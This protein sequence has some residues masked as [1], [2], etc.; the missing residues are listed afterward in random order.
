MQISSIPD[1]RW[2]LF[3]KYMAESDKLPPTMGALKQHIM[4]THVQA[5]I[6]GQASLPHQDLL[7][8]LQNGYHKGDDGQLKPTTTSLPSAPKAILE[9][10]RCHCKKDCSSQR[11]SCKSK[12]LPCT[13]MCLCSAQCD[14]DDDA[15]YNYYSPEWDVGDGQQAPV[16]LHPLK[17]EQQLVVTGQASSM[18]YLITDSGPIPIITNTTLTLKIQRRNSTFVIRIVKESMELLSVQQSLR[19]VITVG[20]KGGNTHLRLSLSDPQEE[21]EHSR[22]PHPE[23]Q[24]ISNMNTAIIGVLAGVV[25]DKNVSANSNRVVAVVGYWSKFLEVATYHHRSLSHPSPTPAPRLPHP[26]PTPASPQPHACLT[27]APHL[28]QASPM[29]VLQWT[30]M[31]LYRERPYRES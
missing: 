21:Q 19:P 3:C 27:P 30:G 26:S 18:P 2:H 1:L 6:W 16:T 5:R 31:G 9:M 24:T 10:V 22:G 11:C 4:R 17:S 8:P 15:V 7:D 14:N 23:S 13:D 28:P 25:L 29:P 20:S 12:A